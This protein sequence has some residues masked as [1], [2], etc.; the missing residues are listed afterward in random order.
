MRFKDGSPCF[1]SDSFY[2]VH[3]HSLYPE[4]EQ[5]TNRPHVMYLIQTDEGMWFAIPLRS[6]IRHRF[7]FH[8]TGTGGLDYTKAIP[9]LDPSYVDETRRAYVRQTDWPI[10]QSNK[11]RIKRGMAAYLFRY[12]KAKAH[13]ERPGNANLLRYS[14]IRYF[15]D[16]L[17]L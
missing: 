12:R 16:E 13:P 17:G 1:L 10:I 15:E 3:P 8:T 6:N 11:P 2:E 9:L 4:I 14:T 5:K 7:C